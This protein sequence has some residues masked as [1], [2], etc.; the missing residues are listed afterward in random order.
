MKN[1]KKLR[2]ERN[3]SQQALAH[4]M[5]VSQQ[6]IN[7]YES[8]KTQPDLHM[9]MALAEFFHTSIDYLVGYTD[10][11]DSYRVVSDLSSD[12]ETPLSPY[13]MDKMK[14]ARSSSTQL[15]R[16]TS[17][18]DSPSIFDTTPKE[19][20]HLSMYRKLNSKMQ[21]SLDS[22]LESFVPDD[23]YLTYKKH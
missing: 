7:K 3:L 5:G 9:L 23:S 2:L 12:D 16:E 4:I 1:L 19:R 18:M 21:Q 20:Y 22:F 13:I 10:N 6:S 11:P 15:L 14:K 8:G 17:A